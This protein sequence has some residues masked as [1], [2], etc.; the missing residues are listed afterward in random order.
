MTF[1]II[2]LLVALE[3]CTSSLE[4][5]SPSS[6]AWGVLKQYPEHD[7]IF[8]YDNSTF[9]DLHAFFQHPEST[10]PVLQLINYDMSS[11]VKRPVGYKF[12]NIVFLHNPFLFERF[13]DVDFNLEYTDVVVFVMYNFQPASK[14]VVSDYH[15]VDVWN[16]RGLEKCSNVIVYDLKSSRFYYVQF[17]VG[18]MAGVLRG[19]EEKGGG[20]PNISRYM[21]E[22]LDFNGHVFHVAFYPYEP[23]ISCK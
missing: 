12:I 8:H 18:A 6:Q 11:N 1:V 19:V 13:S 9:K 22:F 4:H 23:F 2:F 3:E 10:H 21:N 5:L 14:R 16:Q 20:S 17:Y 7:F 15:F